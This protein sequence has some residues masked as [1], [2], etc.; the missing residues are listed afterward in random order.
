M[1]QPVTA[2]KTVPANV[3]VMIGLVASPTLMVMA[4]LLYTIVTTGWLTVSISM[5]I[6]T[7]L[8]VAAYSV[9]ITGKL[10]AKKHKNNETDAL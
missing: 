9:V 6:F 4:M 2:K 1:S 10:P 3:R 7:L 8:G 5:I